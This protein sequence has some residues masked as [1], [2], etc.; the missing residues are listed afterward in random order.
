[1]LRPALETLRRSELERVLDDW[2]TTARDD[3]LPPHVW[4]GAD[5]RQRGW[6]LWLILGG[7]GSGKTRAGA[8]WVR[9]QL[10]GRPPIAHQPAR[11]IALVGPT[12]HEAAAVMVEGVS[13]LLAVMGRARPVF[14]KAARKLIFYNGAVAQ[15]FS[16][17][18][19]EEL[20]G[21]QFD[22]AW[23]DELAKWRYPDH[24]LDMLTLGVTGYIGG[25]SLE[26]VVESWKR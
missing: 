6:H 24:T 14:N 3:Q 7:R 19:P 22:A 12:Y 1:M 9:C 26:K 8:E 18:D 10:R 21:P 11:R 15:L 2:P 23:C 20:R 17:E 4:A 16:G 13:G 25:R 5:A